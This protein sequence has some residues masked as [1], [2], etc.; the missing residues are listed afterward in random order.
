MARKN[1]ASEEVNEYRHRET[2]E[3]LGAYVGTEQDKVL[4]KDEHYEVVGKRTPSP[5]ETTPEGE[6]APT[7]Q[8]GKSR[9]EGARLR[10]EDLEGKSREELNDL[11][12]EAGVENPEGYANKDEV[13]TAILEATHGVP[14][15]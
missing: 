3:T 12:T 8:S 1:T 4:A 7:P 13:K 15:E 5:E 11:A 14:T 9:S 10:A 2:G 6:P